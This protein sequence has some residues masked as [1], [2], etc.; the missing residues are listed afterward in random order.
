[1]L[2]P[3]VKSKIA[4]TQSDEPVLTGPWFM[5]TGLIDQALPP[6]ASVIDTLVEQAV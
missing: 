5:S 3:A 4:P 6:N 1:M 2:V